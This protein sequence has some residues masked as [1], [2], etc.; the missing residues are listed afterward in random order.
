MKTFPYLDDMQFANAQDGYAYRVDS[1]PLYRTGD[2]GKSWE[3]TPLSGSL[4][5]LVLTGGNAYTL[6]CGS[7]GSNCDSD[8]YLAVAAISSDSWTTFPLPGVTKGQIASLVAWGSKLWVFMMPDGGGKTSMLVS[9][10]GGRSF[11]SSACTGL[12]GYSS[13]VVASSSTTLWAVSTGGSLADMSRSTDGGETFV[14]FPEQSP[15]AVSALPGTR[16]FPVSDFEALAADSLGNGLFLTFDGGRSFTRVLRQ[17]Q[18]LAVG[19]ATAT[20]WLA[21][22]NPDPAGANPALS[23]LWLTNNG[24]RV[25]QALAPPRV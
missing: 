15:G 24:G 13:Q 12:S 3:R 18:V 11:T 8:Y 7:G 9:H 5:G 20:D 16:V 2:G 19:F 23:G 1:G 4:Y 14:S 25:W 21:S 17:V 10:D 22:G 6:W